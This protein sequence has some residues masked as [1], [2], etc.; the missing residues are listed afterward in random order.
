MN[1]VFVCPESEDL[2]YSVE[3]RCAAPARALI[4]LAG[5]VLI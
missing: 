5:I 2:K 1:F 3:R 4:E